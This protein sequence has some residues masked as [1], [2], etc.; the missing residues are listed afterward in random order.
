MTF[1]TASDQFT[2]TGAVKG[3]SNTI[4]VIM[5]LQDQVPGGSQRHGRSTPRSGANPVD[6]PGGPLIWGR[7]QERVGAESDEQHQNLN[8]GT[9]EPQTV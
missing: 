7:M 8:R 3:R 5:I 4:V 2:N 1:G 6:S 9:L